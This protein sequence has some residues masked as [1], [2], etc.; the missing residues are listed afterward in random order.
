MKE[1]MFMDSLLRTCMDVPSPERTNTSGKSARP[2]S[3]PERTEPE[4]QR[5]VSLT[6]ALRAKVPQSASTAL[7]KGIEDLLASLNVYE[8]QLEVTVTPLQI[9]VDA[10]ISP[11]YTH[12]VGK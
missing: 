1:R 6:I 5:Y 11:G 3:L 12:A 7:T 8:R 2:F 4:Y 9:L 10:D